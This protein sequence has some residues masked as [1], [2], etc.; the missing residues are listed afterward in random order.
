MKSAGIVRKVDDMGRITLP[1]ELRKV[2]GVKIKDPLEMFTDEDTII[3]KKVQPSLH[4]LW[5][6]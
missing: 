3:L 5:K 4:I 1:I 6:C 2:Y